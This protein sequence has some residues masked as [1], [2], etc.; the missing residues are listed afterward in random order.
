MTDVQTVP[1]NITNADVERLLLKGIS[2]RGT[3]IAD[4][5]KQFS[6]IAVEEATA[7][8]VRNAMSG[9]STKGLISKSQIYRAGKSVVPSLSQAAPVELARLPTFLVQPEKHCV[10]VFVSEKSLS[11]SCVNKCCKTVLVTVLI[12]RFSTQTY[13]QVPAKHKS[14]R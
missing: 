13:E 8:I 2:K 3:R 7:A 14:G 9:K 4:S 1:A 10:C 12:F 11:L 6:R 5:A